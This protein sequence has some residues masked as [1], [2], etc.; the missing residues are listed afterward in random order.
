MFS[1]PELNTI[2][3]LVE[4]HTLS[5][6]AAKHLAHKFINLE[7][8]LLR[9]KVLRGLVKADTTYI[10]QTKIE[11]DSA[12][13]AYLFSGFILSNLNNRVYYHT[14]ATE[15]V[16]NILKPY[17]QT[18]SSVNIKPDQIIQSLNLYID[19]DDLIFDHSDFVFIAF[20]NALC[21]NDLKNIIIISEFNFDPD[22]ILKLENIFNIK[23]N[24]ITKLNKNIESKKIKIDKL[25]FKNKDQFHTDLCQ[26]FAIANAPLL[27]I[28]NAYQAQQAINLVEDM[29]Y[30]EHIHEKMSVYGEYIQT[31]VQNKTLFL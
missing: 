27:Q 12:D 14:Q 1:T 25:L 13:I 17:Y 7:A 24:I 10:L 11:D 16:L 30:S 18:I 28:C 3:A 22:V 29:F 4:G 31:R 6:L 2:L 26:S 8:A 5:D 20:I 19:I 15:P 9:A 23:I 21:H